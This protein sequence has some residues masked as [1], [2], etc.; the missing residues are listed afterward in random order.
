MRE[1]KFGE[2]LKEERTVKGLT[3]RGLSNEINIAQPVIALWETKKREP[4][5]DTLIM[6]AKY[7]KVTTDYMLGLTD[8]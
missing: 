8:Y 4:N 5:L 6:I 7:F 3:Q 1:H 2:R